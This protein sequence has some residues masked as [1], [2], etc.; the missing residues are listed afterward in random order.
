VGLAGPCLRHKALPAGRTE[1]RGDGGRPGQPLIDGE[2]EG[3]VAL[4]CPEPRMEVTGLQDSSLWSGSACRRRMVNVELGVGVGAGAGAAG[5]CLRHTAP[6]IG[7]TAA[8]GDG[9]RPGQTLLEGALVGA[10]RWL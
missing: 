4:S 9:G 3:A 7:R 6:P 10:T 2:P 1:A 8:R 5:P